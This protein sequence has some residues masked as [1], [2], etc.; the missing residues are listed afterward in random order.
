MTSNGAARRLVRG[1]RGRAQS[2]RQ[3]RAATRNLRTN[4]SAEER[5]TTGILSPDE[6][7]REPDLGTEL[8]YTTTGTGIPRFTVTSSDTEDAGL[9]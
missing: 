1:N 2:L 9:V 3:T 8:R 7:D 6:G 5:G 4:R